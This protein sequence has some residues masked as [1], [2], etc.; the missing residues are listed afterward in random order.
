V[1]LSS[2]RLLIMIMMMTT[3]VDLNDYLERNVLSQISFMTS[4]PQILFVI[5][6][7]QRG[8]TQATDIIIIGDLEL[9]CVALC[10]VVLRCVVLR[11]V[12]IYI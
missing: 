9:S 11:C 12:A 2:D 8:K 3:R 6:S 5:R 7:L 1:D 4:R 10:C